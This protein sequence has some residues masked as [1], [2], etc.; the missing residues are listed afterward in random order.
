MLV[1]SVN[2]WEK[3]IVTITFAGVMEAIAGTLFGVVLEMGV[4]C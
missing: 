4:G 3:S 1:P 2:R